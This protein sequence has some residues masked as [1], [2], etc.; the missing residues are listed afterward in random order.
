MGAGAT[1]IRALVDHTGGGV[2]ECFNMYICVCMYVHNINVYTWAYEV[3]HN[4]MNVIVCMLYNTH[5]H[6]YVHYYLLVV[7]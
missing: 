3:Q 5:V 6:V 2:F 7:A 4:I 1:L